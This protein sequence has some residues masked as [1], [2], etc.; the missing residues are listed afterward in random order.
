MVRSWTDGKMDKVCT[1]CK[2]VESSQSLAIQGGLANE[3]ITWCSE[4]MHGG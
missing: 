2:I 1:K 4:E 3:G